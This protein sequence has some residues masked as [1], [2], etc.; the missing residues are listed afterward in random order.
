MVNLHITTNAVEQFFGI[1]HFK[2]CKFT[3]VA[4]EYFATVGRGSIMTRIH[5]WSVLS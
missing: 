1:N 4:I 5:R 3:V 2:L